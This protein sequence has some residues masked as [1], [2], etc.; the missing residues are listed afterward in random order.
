MSMEQP[1]KQVGGAYGIFL[2]EKRPEYTKACAGHQQE[3]SKMAGG[4][5]KKLSDKQKAPYQT[6]YE[7]AKAQFDKG[8]AAF[9]E[10][11]G[12]KIKGARALA[13]E[14][15]KAKSG[16]KVKDANAPK[17]LGGSG[18]G[19]FLAE[20]RATITKSLP[21]GHRLPR[22][23]VAVAKAAGAQWKALSDAMKKSFQD[24][25]AKKQEEYAAAFAEY[26]KT[27]PADA[28]DEEDEDDEEEEEEEE[29]EEE[30]SEPPSKKVRKAGA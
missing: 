10:A 22:S 12:E 21:A 28:E 6:K 13:S 5:W 20:N 19:V 11:G 29:G 25:F 14:K 3:I 15:R 7:E 18:F 27:L 8:M 24:K 2:S 30:A 26:K 23:Q 9:L 17:K 4:A 1:K 16:K